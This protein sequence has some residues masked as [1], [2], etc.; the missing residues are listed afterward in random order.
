MQDLGS[1]DNVASYTAFAP[2]LISYLL[3]LRQA[4]LLASDEGL[5]VGGWGDGQGVE[6][7][8]TDKV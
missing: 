4:F 1:E 5:E 7:R 2:V 6:D 8:S 3:K